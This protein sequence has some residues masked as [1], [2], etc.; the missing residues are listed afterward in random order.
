MTDNIIPN[1]GIKKLFVLT[2][3]LYWVREQYDHYKLFT[4]KQIKEKYGIDRKKGLLLC[5][6]ED[7]PDSDYESDCI[8]G[9]DAI[10]KQ[11]YD[12]FALN[13]EWCLSENIVVELPPLVTNAILTEKLDTFEGFDSDVCD[14][15]NN[16]TLIA[17]ISRT[18][19]VHFL[20]HSKKQPKKVPALIL[21]NGIHKM[22]CTQYKLKRY[23]D[24]EV[25]V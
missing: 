1:V 11:H 13:Q 8:Y 10:S 20:P 25:S 5:Q 19:I 22:V 6:M 16:S 4:K 3:N 21:W 2:N 14:K 7:M 18:Q 24:P 23:D 15:S 9:F 17:E 12:D